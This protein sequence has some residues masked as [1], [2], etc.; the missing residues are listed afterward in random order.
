MRNR[1]P[2]ILITGANGEVGHGLIDYLS[3]QAHMPA[4]VTLDLTP[5]DEHLL[6]MVKKAY[7]GNILDDDVLEEIHQT[8]EIDMIFHLAALLSTTAEKKPELAHAV[9]VQGTVNLLHM[10]IRESESRG[11]SVKFIY[12]SSIAT[13]GLPNLKSKINAGAVKEDDYLIPT[14]MYGCN[15]LYC[16]HM[17]RYYSQHY[18]QLD[19]AI[20][21]NIDFRC[22]RFPGLISAFTVPSGGT[23]DYGPEMIHAA[24]Q[25]Q[26]YECFVRE[27]TIIPFMAMPDAIKA[28]I[29]LAEAER[30]SLSRE[31]YN[32]TAFS[33]SAAEFAAHVK[34]EFPHA[35]VS[36]IPHL[37]RQGIVDT[38]PA[39]LGNPISIWNV[40]SKS[41]FSPIFVNATLK[42]SASKNGR[43]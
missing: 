12:P 35:E 23:S 14:T 24:A 40:L 41:I 15:K 22:V 11:K 27:D 2:I 7:V 13:Y 4:I 6:P 5:L 20:A 42:P 10:A 19:E 18:K 30:E 34:E 21:A 8:Y 3:A 25:E 37:G 39:G 36:Y 16:E 17:G 33:L 26:P 38:W 28:L 1:E 29:Q 9:N 43:F 32:V 31:V